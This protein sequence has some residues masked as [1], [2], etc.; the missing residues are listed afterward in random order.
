M[1][2]LNGFLAR[3]KAD[4]RFDQIYFKW[5][6]QSRIGIDLCDSDLIAIFFKANKKPGGS[7]V[8]TPGFFILLL[9]YVKP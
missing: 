4:G 7:V 6:L 1:K 8:E 2:F 3:M 9:A 5:F